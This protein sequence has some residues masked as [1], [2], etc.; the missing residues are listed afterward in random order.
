MITATMNADEILHEFAYLKPRRDAYA[1]RCDKVMRKWC[2]NNRKDSCWKVINY[3][4]DGTKYTS[5][6]H[7][8]RR[9]LGD[10]VYL[11]HGYIADTNEWVSVANGLVASRSVHFFRRYAER[12]LKQPDLLLN[13]AI[14]KYAKANPFHVKIYT[15]EKS[16]RYAYAVNDG[17]I[18]GYVDKRGVYVD[19]TFVSTEMLGE[20]QR[21][22]FDTVIGVMNSISQDELID[23]KYDKGQYTW[24]LKA[25]LEVLYK[26]ADAIYRQYFEEKGK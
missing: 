15:D 12:C 3:E 20:T 10:R 16:G 6:L 4:L 1:D 18:L 9:F 7:Y 8:S 5:F 19:K 11:T 17:I 26:E 23:M 13:E 22:A 14:Y 25:S 24:I 2:I 21:M